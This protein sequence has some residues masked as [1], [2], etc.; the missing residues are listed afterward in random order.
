M[1]NSDLQRPKAKA[2]EPSTDAPSDPARFQRSQRTYA[3]ALLQGDVMRQA[4]LTQ[5]ENVRRI[6]RRLAEKP[7]RRVVILGC[8]NSWFA[9]I[10]VKL[11]FEH[12]LGVPVEAVQALDYALYSFFPSNSKDLVIGISS[13][14]NTPAVMKAL[15]RAKEKG[16]MTIGFSNSEAA[17]I[18]SEFDEGI[19]VP[20]NA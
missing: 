5:T 13:G 7:I 15:A 3:E 9:A 12:L 11:A 8:G 20:A 6:A 2:K 4:L 16:A 14:G 18:L 17:P 19:Y 1:S 10:G